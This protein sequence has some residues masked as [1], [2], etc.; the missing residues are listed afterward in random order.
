MEHILDNP[1]FNALISGNKQLA[2]GNELVKYFDKDVSPF[3]GFKENTT[4][5]FQL[6]YDLISHTGPVGFISPAETEIPKQWKVANTIKCLQMIFEGEVPQ[7]HNEAELIPL[8]NQH[9]PQMLAL[10]KLTNPGPFAPRTIDFGHY[11][12]VFDGE[13]LVAMAG[14]RMHPLPFAEISAV[15]THPDY[16]GKGYAKQLLLHHINRIKAAGELPMLHVRYDN[17]RAIKVYE[18]TGFSIRKEIYFTI[19]HK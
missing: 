10:T 13:K 6:L 1:A 17:E 5:S 9:V 18:S 16:T 4:Y 15:C 12:G 19:M 2:N 3:V 7:E 11:K 14:Q 8:T